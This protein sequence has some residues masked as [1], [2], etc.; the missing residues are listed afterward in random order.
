MR[1]LI[2]DSYYSSFLNSFYE[3]HPE[4]KSLPFA[5]HW[6]GLMSECFGTADFYSSNLR[7]LGHE[8]QEVIANNEIL[9]R[10]WAVEN[11]I[12]LRFGWCP[13]LHIYRDKGRLRLDLRRQARWLLEILH[14]Q[15]R[16]FSAD[17]LYVQNI[18][19][20]P[21]D[22]LR[23][24]KRHVRLVIGQHASPL[25]S[26]KMLGGYDLILSSLPNMVSY[27]REQGIASEY[28][29]LGFEPRVFSRLS[30]LDTT[31]DVAHIGGFGPVHNERNT[32]LEDVS[33]QV[34]VD[35]WG[36]GIDNVSADSSLRRKYHGEAWG[37]AMYNIRHNSRICLN[38]HITSVSD[39]FGNNCTLY[40]A[41]GVGTL[42]ITDYKDNLPE[43]FEPWREVVPYKS[44][45]ECAE[46]VKHYLEHEEE[47]LAIARAG[48]ERTLRE[49]TFYHR[50]QELTDII[51]RYLHKP[52]MATQRIF[53]T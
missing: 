18:S 23:D 49:H 29:R 51:E 41:T 24:I 40:E 33:R 4:V 47:R 37:L 20:L 39:G 31:Y 35:L 28:F 10:Q 27:F 6:Q 53:G 1:L 48:Q 19:W 16:S 13:S 34:K 52:E 26:G 5:D 14:A 43:L 15:I 11:N 25:P 7:K 38:K 36:Y 46:L 30:K 17:V 8:A 2:V 44:P 32:F 9:Q 45:E 12:K 21:T 3:A 50:M 42:L 22:F